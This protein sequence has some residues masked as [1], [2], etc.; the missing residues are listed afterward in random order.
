MY[1]YSCSSKLASS[2]L[3]RQKTQVPASDHCVVIITIMHQVNAA[4]DNFLFQSG[5]DRSGK[6]QHTVHRKPPKVQVAGGAAGRLRLPL[7]ALNG[8]YVL[9]G[10]L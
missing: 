5:G 7:V 4:G 8:G 3:G 9:L 1:R 6:S 2:D 10:R